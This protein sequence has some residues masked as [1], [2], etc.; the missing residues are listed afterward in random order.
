[1]RTYAGLR[2]ASL[3]HHARI[4]ERNAVH[5]R[6]GYDPDASVQFVLDKAL[7]LRG[8]VLDV[9]TGKGRFVVRLAQHVSNITTVDIDPREQHCARL[10]AAYVQVT[11]RIQ[12]VLAD[13][14]ELPWPAASFDAVTSWNVL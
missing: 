13:A 7:P 9:G 3:A 5:R 12:F 4:E 8:R 14:R 2:R 6:F 11:R 10:E 1:M